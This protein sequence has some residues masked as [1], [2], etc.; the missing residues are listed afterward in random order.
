VRV[1][2]AVGPIERFEIWWDSAIVSFGMSRTIDWVA[3]VRPPSTLVN[4]MIFGTWF[5]AESACSM[6][7]KTSPVAG[8]TTIPVRPCSPEPGTSRWD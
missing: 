5:V 6:D 7:A 4:L 3:A 2:L 1:E 8:S